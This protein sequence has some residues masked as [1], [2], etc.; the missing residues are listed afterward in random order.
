L[1]RRKFHPEILTGSPDLAVKQGRGVENKPSEILGSK[2]I[3]VT[4]LT[5]W[6]H[7]TLSVTWPL[8]SA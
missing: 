4:S 2:H 7:A 5:F 6:D 3:V 8:D 1:P